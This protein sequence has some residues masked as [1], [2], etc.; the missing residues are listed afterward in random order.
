MPVCWCAC[1]LTEQTE[2]LTENYLLQEN[3]EQEQLV[4]QRV[5]NMCALMQG[6]SHYFDTAPTV[7]TLIAQ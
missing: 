2:C 3:T 6:K 1:G 4:A 7:C 5:P